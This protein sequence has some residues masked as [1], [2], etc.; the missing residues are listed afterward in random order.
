MRVCLP[1]GFGTLLAQ[2]GGLPVLRSGGTRTWF[3]PRLAVSRAGSVF[4]ADGN[5]TDERVREQVTAFIQGFSE[6]TQQGRKG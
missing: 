5:L 1:G 6:F 4:D 3:G 2:T